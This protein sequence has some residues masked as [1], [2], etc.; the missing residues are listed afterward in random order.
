MHTKSKQNEDSDRP[1]P[2]VAKGHGPLITRRRMLAAGTAGLAAAMLAAC[3]EEESATANRLPAVPTA[4]HETV[5]A[6]AVAATVTEAAPH[7]VGGLPEPG[8]QRAVRVAFTAPT[9]SVWGFGIE[10]MLLSAGLA[11]SAA[12]ERRYRYEGRTITD[13]FKKDYSLSAQ[14]DSLPGGGADLLMFHAHDLPD[15]L[16]AEQ[17]LPLDEHLQSDADFDRAVYWPRTLETGFHEGVQY[18]LPI[19]G[20]PVEHRVQSRPGQGVRD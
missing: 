5:Q 13:H 11:A 9:W 7:D 19:G 17:L 12:S 16:A 8:A 15:L 14:L 20:G 3:G 18:T 10:P 6:R 4:S 2:R 1:S